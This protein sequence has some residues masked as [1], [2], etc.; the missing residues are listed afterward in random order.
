MFECIFDLC[1]IFIVYNWPSARDWVINLL[2]YTRIIFS[3]W[4][5]T[6]STI[7]S[8]HMQLMPVSITPWAP[9]TKKKHEI[10]SMRILDPICAYWFPK[11]LQTILGMSSWYLTCHIHT[12]QH[13]I[14]WQRRA[15]WHDS[16]GHR[17]VGYMSQVT[18]TSRCKEHQKSVFPLPSCGLSG[19]L[20]GK[21]FWF[22]NVPNH[23]RIHSLFLFRPN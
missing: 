3:C 11:A 15:Q 2:Q 13:V 10:D 18:L 14:K 22:E 20:Y 16:V 8:P 5:W 21:D 23:S 9:P 17:G 19:T 12:L 6:A 7:W 4:F 1:M